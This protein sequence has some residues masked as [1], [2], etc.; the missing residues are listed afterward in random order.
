MEEEE[1]E[2]EEN[3]EQTMAMT[4]PTEPPIVVNAVLESEMS[5]KIRYDNKKES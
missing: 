4:V 3:R 5:W 2:M 1:D